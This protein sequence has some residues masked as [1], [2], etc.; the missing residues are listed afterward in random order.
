MRIP[1]I[2]FIEFIEN[3]GILRLLSYVPL[4]TVD[5]IYSAMYIFKQIYHNV[6]NN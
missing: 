1:L 6:H 5:Y 3:F 2:E 4:L